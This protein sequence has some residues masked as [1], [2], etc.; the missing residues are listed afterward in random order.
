[1]CCWL[2]IEWNAT[3][4]RLEARSSSAASSGSRRVGIGLL[5]LLLFLYWEIP[6]I[7]LC[8]EL[9]MDRVVLWYHSSEIGGYC[10][11]FWPPKMLQ[12]LLYFYEKKT[13][14]CFFHFSF[15]ATLFFPLMN[16]LIYVNIHQGIH[17]G[18]KNKVAWNE[19]WR[20]QLW[21]FIYIKYGK[22][23]SVSLE[24]Q[25]EY[26]PLISEEWSITSP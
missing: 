2:Y 15:H 5:L 1:M 10:L 6:N 24:H 16:A 19:K 13:Q 7:S 21:V 8:K 18:K 14:S 9:V 3:K 11:S 17:L 22:F 4:G 23:W 20:K 26:K 12:N 25:V